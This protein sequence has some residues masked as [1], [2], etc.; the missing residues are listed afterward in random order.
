MAEES[1]DKD[2]LDDLLAEAQEADPMHQ[3]GAPTPIPQKDDPIEKEPLVPYAPKQVVKQEETPTT[4]PSATP[5][6]DGLVSKFL[7][8]AMKIAKRAQDRFEEDRAEVQEVIDHLKNK[9][10]NGLKPSSAELESLVAALRVKT[11]ATANMS[12]L[13]DMIARIVS[14]GK[15]QMQEKTSA[16]DLDELNHIKQAL[17][18]PEFGDTPKDLPDQQADKSMPD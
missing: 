1:Q 12:K 2:S 8:D 4:P 17:S 3:E 16:F 15:G 13:G 18:L 5:E 10:F 14:S 6:L 9:V 11:D 7:S